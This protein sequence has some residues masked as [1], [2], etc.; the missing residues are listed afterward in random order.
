VSSEG[1]ST[2]RVETGAII[3]H[4]REATHAEYSIVD[5][6]PSDDFLTIEL[7]EIGQF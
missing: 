7:A 3:E 5:F 4:D 6:H 2:D 1:D